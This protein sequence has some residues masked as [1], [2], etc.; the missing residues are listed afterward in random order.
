[1][2]DYAIV[3]FGATGFTGGKTAEYLARRAPPGLRWALAGRSQAKLDVLKARLLTLAPPGAAI[4]TL[5]ASVEDSASLLRMAAATR[6]LLTTVGPFIDYG[7]PVVQACVE[8]RTDYVDSTGEPH[9]FRLLHARYAGPARD[10]G[11]RIVPSCGFDAIP[12]DLG[13]LYT[14]RQLPRDQPIQ[15]AGYM[16]L[17]GVF[18][19]GT[20]RSAIKSWVTP[21]DPAV[22]GEPEPR[23]GRRVRLLRGKTHKHP[24][25]GAWV[26]ALET[27][28][29]MVVTRSA[30]TLEDYGPDFSYSHNAQHVSFGQ[31]AAAHV[32]FGSVAYLVRF[33]PARAFF[34]NMVKKSGE[35]PT[36]AQMDEGWFKLR[37]IAQ[38]A[39]QTVQTEVAGGDPG[40]GETSKMLAE[41]AL[42]LAEAP[43]S[44]TPLPQRA[45]VLTAAEAMGD[46]LLPRLEQAGLRFRVL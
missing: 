38:C 45:G 44:S 25:L 10:R 23:A 22:P 7:E 18:S 43:A 12:A 3:V 9:F 5:V 39:G 15:L 37:F 4:G 29:G 20:E 6:V 33:G 32:V 35:G 28:D 34:L 21:R 46:A 16:S 17:H 42:C 11:V 36:Q 40:Y 13:A 27:V 1:V 41:S 26:N 8:Q 31:L 14:V 19:G 24:L 2:R 30:A